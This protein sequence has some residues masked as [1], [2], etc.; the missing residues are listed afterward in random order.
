MTLQLLTLAGYLARNKWR[1]RMD[2][3]THNMLRSRGAHEHQIV[4]LEALP[5]VNGVALLKFLDDRP[6]EGRQLLTDLLSIFGVPEG[7]GGP[8]VK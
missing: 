7:S 2:R 4:A 8:E 1:K 5:H 3:H 6:A